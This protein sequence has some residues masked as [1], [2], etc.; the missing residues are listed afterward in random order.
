VI[1]F[2]P[3]VRIGYLTMQLFTVLHMAAVWSFRARVDVD[4]NSIED[5]AGV[6]MS[7]SL[8]GYGL[9]ID[10]DTVG[11]KPADLESLAAFARVWLDPQFDVVYEG[12]HLHVE[13]DAHR[14]PLRK[15]VAT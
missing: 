1:R 8:H 4:V 11:D 5:G 2:K 9:A 10:L 6:H 14:P 7:G 13:W 3:D 15:A 12:D